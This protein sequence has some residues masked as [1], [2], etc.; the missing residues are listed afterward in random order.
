MLVTLTSDQWLGLAYLLIL[1]S[2]ARATHQETSML[3]AGLIGVNVAAHPSS[4]LVVV[5]IGLGTYL[6]KILRP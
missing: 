6:Y 5:V 3:L 1:W 4:M 2:V